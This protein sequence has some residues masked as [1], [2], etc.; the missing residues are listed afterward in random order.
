M[1]KKKKNVTRRRFLEQVGLA[2]GS[3][4]LYETMTALGLINLPE[5]WAGRP[6][7]PQGSGKGK[8]VVI[9]GAGIGGV[10]GDCGNTRR[11]YDGLLTAVT[12]RLRL[13]DHQPRRRNVLE[14]GHHE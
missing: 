1:S 12:P 7:L 4:A 13:L 2:G 9:L 6:E 8:S 11:D 3:A 14:V 10:R 5:A